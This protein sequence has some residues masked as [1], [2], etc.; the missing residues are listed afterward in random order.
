[1]V[2]S[3]VYVYGGTSR[4]AQLGDIFALTPN[5][6]DKIATPGLFVVSG[7]APAPRSYHTATVIENRHI[8]IIGGRTT[9]NVALK[10]VHVFDV[11]TREWR[12]LRVKGEG[13]GPRYN[14]AAVV[15]RNKIL[16]FGGF[17]GRAYLNDAHLLDLGSLMW[18]S[19]ALAGPPPAPRSR[20]TCTSVGET[21]MVF[22]G[23]DDSIK[24]NDL[25]VLDFTACKELE[26]AYR[27]LQQ[28]AGNRLDELKWGEL[29]E[30]ELLHLNGLK[31]ITD[32]KKR[33]FLEQQQQQSAGGTEDSSLGASSPG[34]NGLTGDKR[35]RLK[36]TTVVVR[37]MNRDTGEGVPREGAALGLGWSVI[38]Q[39]TK[40]VDVFEE[41]RASK[42][43][44]RY[45]LQGPVPEKQ[46]EAMLLRAGV[47][48]ADLERFVL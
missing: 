38:N 25:T 33:L 35:K 5:K 20:H 40:P 9:G 16:V 10:D 23:A 11:A 3:T 47:P 36:F 19:P 42:R 29:E 28:L 39:E 12:E 15:L 41:E 6:A 27:Q 43:K 13:P 45:K 4:N 1:V 14:H 24:M 7:Q 46:R 22:G 2:D 21:M 48:P 37:S 17:N 26:K 31:A 32:A 44:A 8:V 34:D 30:L 18:F